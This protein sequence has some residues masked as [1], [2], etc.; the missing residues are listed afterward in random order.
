MKF[1]YRNV[2]LQ[3]GFW[4]DKQKLNADVTINA[5]YDRF[6]ET[7]RIDAFKFD[8]K[9]G[10]PNKPHIFWDSDVAKWMEGAAYILQSEDRPDLAEK[11]EWLIDRIEENQQED[12]YFNIYYTVVEPGQRFTKRSNHELYC[13]GHLMEAAC[14]YYEATGRDRFLGLMEKYADCIARIFV[15]EASA[16]FETPGHE[17]IELA[18]FRM[19]R[20]TGKKKYMELAA[21]FLEKRGCPENTE[22]QIFSVAHYA[23]SHAPI[24]EQKTAYGHAVRAMYLYAGMADLALE[25]GDAVLLDTCRALFD[26]VTTKKM[27]VTGGLGSTRIGEAFT[28]PYDLPNA[29]AY[30]ET[31]AS[32]GMT[33]FAQRMIAADPANAAKYADI[34]EL[35]MYNGALSGLSLG[36]DEF[37]YEN[38][39]EINLTERGRITGTKEQ[40]RWPIAERVK[41]FSC[42]CCPPNLNRWL[43][44][45]GTYFY[46]MDEE[47]GEV[48]INQF[49]TSTYSR[50][51]AEVTVETD[52]PRSGVIRIR[53]NRSVRVRIPGWCHGFTADKAYVMERGYA[54]FAAGEILLDLTIKPELLAAS[55]QVTQDLGRAALRRGPIV[56]CAEAIDNG[57]RVHDLYFDAASVGAAIYDGERVIVPGSRRVDPQP[58][59]LYTPLSEAFVPVAVTMIPYHTFANRGACDML[60][61]LPYR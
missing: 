6:A 14:A 17:E 51:A 33:Y 54:C 32:I 7:G 45:I 31:C 44:S 10:E 30:T 36:G 23:Q 15:E 40:E 37:F 4:Y 18:L 56:Y 41:V 16:A 53:T 59:I 50:G 39:L 28:I 8:W 19:Y 22:A 13:A 21:H 58:G 5:V 52:Y 49:G 57:G 55:V 29:G 60:V 35:E 12:G 26:D 2:T 48:Y 20:T 25:T 3:G 24:R 9:E 34:I 42:S 27:Y 11:I 61:F 47:S 38:P 43:A 1:D 46:A